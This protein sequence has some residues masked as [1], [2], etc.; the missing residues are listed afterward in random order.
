MTT[1]AVGF[2]CPTEVISSPS[3]L[4]IALLS[5]RGIAFNIEDLGNGLSLVRGM[6]II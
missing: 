1:I 4:E 5:Q 6:E 2:Y 3:N